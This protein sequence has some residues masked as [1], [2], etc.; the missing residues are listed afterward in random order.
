M[1]VAIEPLVPSEL[2]KMLEALR[3]INKSY[4]LISTKVEESGEHII[5]GTGELA[6]DCALHDL[7]KMYSEIEIKVSDPS[8]RFCETVIDT[9]SRMCYADSPNKKNRVIDY[10]IFIFLYLK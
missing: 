5:C 9:S 7:R 6:L 1:K 2:P 3:K 8:V 4:P 10:I